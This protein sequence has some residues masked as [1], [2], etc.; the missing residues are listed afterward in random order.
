[1]SGRRK[2]QGE[3]TSFSATQFCVA[4]FSSEDLPVFEAVKMQIA[5]RIFNN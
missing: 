2:R 5:P 3:L 4:F 1:M